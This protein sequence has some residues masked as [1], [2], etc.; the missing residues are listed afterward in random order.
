MQTQLPP[1]KRINIEGPEGESIFRRFL[2]W[3]LPIE[4]TGT[5]QGELD[6]VFAHMS[7]DDDRALVLVG[8]LVVENAIDQLLTVYI[9]GYKTLKGNRDF[10]F[11]MKISLA[12]SLRLCPSRLF[13]AADA[14]RLIRNDFAHELSN[15]VFDECKPEHLQSIEGHLR[16]INIEQAEGSARDIFKSL[17]SMLFLALRGYH[18]HIQGLN[19]FLRNSEVFSKQFR[20]FCETEYEQLRDETKNE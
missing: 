17:A 20:T 7:S 10:T 5:I 15:S 6:E 14:I 19:E 18:F 1:E 13:S 2:A 16:H 8:A 3:C 11:S 12:R 4:W 9:P